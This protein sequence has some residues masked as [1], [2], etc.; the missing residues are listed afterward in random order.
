MEFRQFVPSPALKSYV[1]SFYLFTS[2]KDSEFS[3]VVFPSGTMEMIFNLGP[4]IWESSSKA[5]FKRTPPLELWGQVTGPLPIRSKGKHVMLGVRFFPHSAVYFL[6]DK[7]E[8]FNNQIFDLADV[9]GNEVKSL[10]HQLLDCQN[11]TMRIRLVETFLIH[12][13]SVSKKKI[14][15]VEK[16]ADLLTSVKKASSEN[17]F[18]AVADHFGITTRYLHKLIFQHTGLSPKFVNKISRFQRSLRLV[19]KNES[20]LTS[21]AFDCGYFDQSHFIRE[22]KSFT[23][24][25]PTAYLEN[26]FPVNQ[27]A[28]Q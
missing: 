2:D 25:T 22:F 3:D 26:K 19:S 27:T 11:A 17:G 24:F 23:S 16:I 18:T 13:L 9:M 28:I 21:I 1:E 20:P 15:K 6:H 12:R 14:N 7:I 5:K 10:H 4:G 8:N